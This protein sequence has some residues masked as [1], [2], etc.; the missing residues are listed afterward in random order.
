MPFSRAAAPLALDFFRRLWS[1]GTHKKTKSRS[2]SSN[3]HDR[4]SDRTVERNT[5]GLF[6]CGT[7]GFEPVPPILMSKGLWVKNERRSN[8][9]FC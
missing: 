9:R 5:F 7:G 2:L 3:K 6:K 1:D 4:E 8:T